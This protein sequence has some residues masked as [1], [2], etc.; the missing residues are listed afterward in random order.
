MVGKT[1]SSSGLSV[2]ED[3]GGSRASVAKSQE[4]GQLYN[5]GRKPTKDASRFFSFKH[6]SHVHESLDEG[7]MLAPYAPET[8]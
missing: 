1:V 8:R 5:K 3:K 6:R 7:S 4:T 2:A